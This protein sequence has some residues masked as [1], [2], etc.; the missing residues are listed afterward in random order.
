M[1]AE[2]VGLAGFIGI[3]AVLSLWG[4]I[5]GWTRDTLIP[6]LNQK[7][8]ALA[9]LAEK[10]L[11]T[12]DRVAAPLLRAAK[13]AWVQLREWLLKVMVTLRESTGNVWIKTTVTWLLV[14]LEAGKK[15]EIWKREEESKV[16]WESLPDDV[17]R[18]ALERR[19]KRSE[20]NVTAAQDE[21]L[22]ELAQ[23]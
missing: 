19:Q 16:N 7:W 10:A 9:K 12:A 20:I 1:I 8:P 5:V 4:Q 17:R 21:A 15:D 3:F 22:L 14:N 23:S 13:Q 2:L 18:E 11:I 6:W